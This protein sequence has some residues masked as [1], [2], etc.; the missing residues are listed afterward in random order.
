[1]GNYSM[2]LLEQRKSILYSDIDGK[3]LNGQIVRDGR[4]EERRVGVV[5][6]SGAPR[7]FA[8]RLVSDGRIWVNIKSYTLALFLEEKIKEEIE[9]GG[10]HEKKKKVI[11]M[12]DIIMGNKLEET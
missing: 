5:C 10:T 11:A 9:D 7:P 2:P 1:M 12:L 6:Q 4:E 3:I 8:P